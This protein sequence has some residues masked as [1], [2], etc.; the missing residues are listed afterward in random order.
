MAQ[1]QAMHPS[2]GVIIPQPIL[3][4]LFLVA[5]GYAGYFIYSFLSREESLK[6]AKEEKRQK[7][8]DRKRKL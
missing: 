2:F 3:A 5:I 7:K 6:K 8:L 1:Q 4:L